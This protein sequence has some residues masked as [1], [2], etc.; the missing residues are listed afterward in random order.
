MIEIKITKVSIKQLV[1]TYVSSVSIGDAAINEL[2]DECSTKIWKMPGSEVDKFA[3]AVIIH[4]AKQAVKN[5]KKSVSAKDMNLAIDDVNAGKA[6]S[7]KPKGSGL[8]KGG[9][10]MPKI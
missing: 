2:H 6:D 1:S 5:K 4:A 9:T 7:S 10:Q 3:T 8:G